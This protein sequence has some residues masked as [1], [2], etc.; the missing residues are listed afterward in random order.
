M[1]QVCQHR[2][3]RERHMGVLQGFT[4]TEAP[5]AQPE[6]WAA[7][8]SDNTRTRV[9]GG[10]SLDEL[11][12]RLTAAVLDVAHNHPGGLAT[13][14]CCGMSSRSANCCWMI[15][16]GSFG[17]MPDMCIV[18]VSAAICQRLN[19]QVRLGSDVM[20]GCRPQHQHA[21]D[22]HSQSE[23]AGRC[24]CPGHALAGQVLMLSLLCCAVSCRDAPA[25]GGRVVV[26]SHGGALHAL[27]RAARGYQAKG[28]VFNCSI[29][30]LL[31]EADATRSS[32]S[33][34]HSR[35][36]QQQQQQSEVQGNMQTAAD[37]ASAAAAGGSQQPHLNPDDPADLSVKVVAA[38]A[39]EIDVVWCD[40][41][42]LCQHCSS[43]PSSGGGRA[44]SDGH[45]GHTD[46]AA[47]TAAAADKSHTAVSSTPDSAGPAASH[48]ASSSAVGG[49]GKATQG[50][51]SGSM[52]RCG[53]G[54][55]QGGRLALLSWNDSYALQAAHLQSD[56]AFGGSSRAG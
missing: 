47:T 48:A 52:Q 33:S 29:S 34:Q 25:S 45:E 13:R 28:K 46:A 23:H 2:G 12:E 10:E 4:Y 44:S 11:R 39:D 14:R 7:L 18:I 6:A 19:G 43:S 50:R 40:F 54:R 27:H 41:A 37:N 35:Q 16:S 9:P 1:Q 49:A 36:Q 32:S 56:K 3:L 5:H 31:A 22:W 55:V 15:F 20:G 53:G 24:N 30:V 51:K 42:E 8:Q 17:G 38:D 21:G 26:I